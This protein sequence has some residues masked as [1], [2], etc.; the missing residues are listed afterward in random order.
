MTRTE[1]FA[2]LGNAVRDY[3]GGY[4]PETGKWRAPPQPNAIARVHRWLRA[5]GIEP[6]TVME[7]IDG[8]KTK[9]EF[10]AWLQTIQSNERTL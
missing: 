8:F 1:K 2:K 10:R 4:N 7:K 6:V 5:L 3:R 9:D